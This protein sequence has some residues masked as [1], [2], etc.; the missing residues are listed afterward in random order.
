MTVYA[1]PYNQADKQC[2]GPST[3]SGFESLDQV[4]GMMGEPMHRASRWLAYAGAGDE[5]I[6]Y[7][8]FIFRVDDPAIN[9]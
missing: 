9:P 3:D 8:N 6:A 2:T 4:V 7:S 1:T 5:A